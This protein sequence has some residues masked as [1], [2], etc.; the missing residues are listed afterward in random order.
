M[1]IIVGSRW[2][3]KG[4]GVELVV[5][6][7]PSAEVGLECDGELREFLDSSTPP[8]PPTSPASAP[9]IKRYVN[10]TY[11]IEVLCTKP[12]TGPLSVSE[13]PMVLKDAEPLPSSD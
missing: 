8:S 6:Q 4:G 10:Q 9:D 2:R 13:E 5:V 7:P 12:G 3:S 11:S 1:S